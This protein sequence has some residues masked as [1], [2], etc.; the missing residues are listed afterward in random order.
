MVK[1]RL[2]GHHK[3]TKIL[4]ILWWVSLLLDAH[5]GSLHVVQSEAL[6][7]FCCLRQVLIVIGEE[8][9]EEGSSGTYE[10]SDIFTVGL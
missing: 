6:S 2:I 4:L 3:K 1:A 9:N 5:I 10:K 7:H 8:V